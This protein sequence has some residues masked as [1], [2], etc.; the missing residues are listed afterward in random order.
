MYTATI[1]RFNADNKQFQNTEFFRIC[2]KSTLESQLEDFKDFENDIWPTILGMHSY[3]SKV[4]SCRKN[5]IE[6]NYWIVYLCKLG[7]E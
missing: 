4:F 2:D 6:N 7:N 1:I 3:E 5:G